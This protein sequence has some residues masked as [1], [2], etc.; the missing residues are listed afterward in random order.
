MLE[1][2]FMELGVGD[3]EWRRGMCIITWNLRWCFGWEV[4]WNMDW[5]YGLAVSGLVGRLELGLVLE[6]A[7]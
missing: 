1:A 7:G 5:R 4:M 6:S 2:G 3:P